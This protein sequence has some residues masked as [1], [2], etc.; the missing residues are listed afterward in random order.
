MLLG[1]V[2]VVGNGDVVR[3]GVLL[4]G[5]GLVGCMLL[6]GREIGVELVSVDGERGVWL[7]GRGVGKV[8]HG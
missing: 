7:G 2:G 5:W 6:V 4:V 8:I 1:I 3:S